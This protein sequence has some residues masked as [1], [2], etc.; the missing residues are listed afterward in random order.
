MRGSSAA[1]SNAR[2]AAASRR[3][4]GRRHAWRSTFCRRRRGA[5]APLFGPDGRCAG[6]L[7][8]TGIDAAERPE[9]KHLA[10]Q[11]ARSIE[12][13]LALAQPHR[14]VLRLNWPGRLLGDEGDGLV[15]VDADGW[16]S[17]S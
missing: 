1:G 17:A 12:N 3:A 5:G 14:I 4:S 11:A 7:D 15:C 10:A 2:G 16:V 8:L 6:M 13:A 9:L